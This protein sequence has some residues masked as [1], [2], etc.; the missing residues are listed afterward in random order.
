MRGHLFRSIVFGLAAALV[1]LGVVACDDDSITGSGDDTEFIDTR[2]VADVASLDAATIDPDAVNSW[3][4]AFGPTGILWVANAGSGT[5]TLYDAAGTKNSLVVDIPT[6]GSATGGEPTGIVYNSTT[7]FTIPGEG[8]AL[9]IFAGED[10]VISAW[11]ASIGDAVLVADQSGSDAVYK[12]IAIGTNASANYLYATNFKRNLVDV[13]DTDFQYV[14][15]FTDATI[16]TGYAPFGIR[17]IDGKLYVTY[18]K[19]EGPD[20]EDD[21]PGVGNGY[22]VV[23][24][25]D[26]TVSKRFASTGN[27]NSPWGIAVAPSGF[28]AFSGD[29]LIG[30]FGD[31]QI[32]AYNPTTGAFV[33]FLRDEDGDII[34]IDGLW[35][36]T[37]G[38]GANAATL[39]Y[40]AGPDDGAHGLIGKIVKK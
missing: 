12:G 40:A 38:T 34:Q 26:G 24:N 13:F 5:S 18:A 21:D 6:T 19:Q 36:L 25:T 15:S 3:G 37:F 32:G 35:G 11:N 7:S 4:L 23:F 9:F 39:Y 1:T 22:V 2:L 14:S 8:T 33:G 28:G 10:G 17:N 31:G 20:N 30:N 27:L 29:I 16:P